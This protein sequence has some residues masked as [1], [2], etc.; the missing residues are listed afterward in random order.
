MSDLKSSPLAGIALAR[1]EP[2]AGG[3]NRPIRLADPD[4]V[5]YVVHGAVDV[6]TAQRLG[7]G[8][9]SDFR[10]L[11]RAGPG[12]LL[13]ALGD[14]VEVGDG[15]AV[16]VAKGLPGSELRRVPLDLL[17]AGE[18]RD[19]LV[20]QID[21]WV[22][23]FAAAVA[24][25][26]IPR[27]RIDH[28]LAPGSEAE[29]EIGSR[30]SARRGVVWAASR[31]GGTA[32]LGLEEPDEDG[33][34]L[35]PLTADAWLTLLCPARVGGASSPALNRDGRLLPAL[36]QFH[37]LA[38]G[39]GEMNRRLLLADM[40]NWQVAR[41][42]SRRRSEDSARRNLFGVLDPRRSMADESGFVLLGA[43]NVV[44]RHEGIRFRAPARRRDSENEEPL[45]AEILE[46][47]GVRA[48]RVV[49]APPDRWWLGDSGAMLAVRSDD[50]APVALVP[51]ASGRYRM[52]DPE[53]G[54]SERVTAERAR[55]LA[56]DAYY[57]YRPLPDDRP[58]DSGI[59][60]RHAFHNL[61][62]DLMRFAAAG[63]LV[64]VVML[65]PAVL[66]GMIV[67]DVLPSGTGRMLAELALCLALIA[68]T[69][70]LLQTLQGTALMRLEGRA[71]ARAGAALWDRILGF[72]QRFF[73]RFTAGDLS[74]RAMA[75]QG[76]R[77]RI[78]GIV[79]NALL[80]V[81][82]LLPTFVLLFVYD[83]AAGWLGLGLGLVSL[84]VTLAIGM[85]QVKHHH[86]LFAVSRRLTGELLQLLNGIG[87]LRSTGSE[88][89]A[90]AIWARG[91]REQK[92]TEMRI[93]RIEEH[94][95]AFT[96]AAPLFAA[97]ALFAVA[98]REDGGLGVGD[99]LTIYA[100][101]MVFY[102]AVATLGS[103]FSAVAAIVPACEQVSPII[104]A[105]PES[106]SAGEPPPELSGDVRL[107]GVS[108]GYTQAG[109][110][111]L[112]EVS[113]HARPGEFVALVGESG[114]GKSTVF[115]LMLGLERPLSGT[116][117]YD[118]YDLERLNLRAV[119]SQVGMVVQEASMQ[120]GM[121]LDNIV[122]MS[123]E[124]TIDDAWRAAR[125]AAVD[126]D[127]MAMPM[128]MFTG[129]GESSATF[130]GGQVQ[131]IMLAAALVRNPGILLL[132]EAT[133]WLDND[134]QA[135]VM[136]GVEELS[137]TRIVSAHRLSTIRRADRIYV[138]ED[139]QVAQE[140]GFDDLME[141]EGVFRDLVRRQMA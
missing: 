101:F 6:F 68:V 123:S 80:S 9:E 60:L 96:T 30:L 37:R 67:D 102:G 75:F 70:A 79:A 20:E 17:S 51:G 112:R 27:P 48:R 25:D 69:G 99:F 84:G 66:L 59:L 122:G 83:A 56:R 94:L 104:E 42:A 130:S 131:R 63:S 61:A 44:G 78:S 132:D 34:G 137:A 29:V 88:G 93:G 139:G 58:V 54:R 86:R 135:R 103:S 115:R 119:R 46:A 2:F 77:D 133:N 53:S 92:Q 85:A 138:L 140:G 14:E 38:L 3:G 118:G 87:K 124:L 128:G 50:G 111:V 32:F 35:V 106:T 57:F 33:L 82:F 41:T 43:L 10:H 19:R 8:R 90:F 125:L 22:S 136:R 16:L 24:R 12:R 72:P 95:V 141:A 109:P 74:V 26:V 62:G 49:L 39:A 116:V 129:V 21:A 121:V 28:F 64:G 71:A 11:L 126:G 107:E 1:G 18:L 127:I 100:A 5:W 36:A 120:P 65:A 105:V 23:D 7:D 134:S 47:S 97:A 89:T 117:Y 114:A 45:L 15:T 113:I 108:F 91:Y 98:L 81:V 31:D 52:V 4:N 110:L 13:F 76:L 55:T 40:S 73:R